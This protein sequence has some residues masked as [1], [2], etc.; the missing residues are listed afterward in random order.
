MNLKTLVKL[1]AHDGGQVEVSH[2]GYRI[3]LIMSD[4][5]A[6]VGPPITAGSVLGTEVKIVRHLPPLTWRVVVGQGRVTREG[7]IGFTRAWGG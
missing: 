5:Y 2:I 1:A 7:T 4:A 3:L 6:P